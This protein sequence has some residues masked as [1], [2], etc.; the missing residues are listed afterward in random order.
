[1]TVKG[2]APSVVANLEAT[3]PEITIDAIWVDANQS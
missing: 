1:M 3:T 2:Q